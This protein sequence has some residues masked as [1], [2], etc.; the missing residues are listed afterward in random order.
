M[1]SFQQAFSYPD[2]LFL[3]EHVRQDFWELKQIISATR[4]TKQ[5]LLNGL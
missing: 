3:L 1:L 2:A 4:L 5:Q